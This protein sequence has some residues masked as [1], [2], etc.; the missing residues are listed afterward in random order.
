MRSEGHWPSWSTEAGCLAAVSSI[1]FTAMH[2][3]ENL[4]ILE[5]TQQDR[6]TRKA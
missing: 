1:Y 2:T 4:V 6:K 5:G 3:A